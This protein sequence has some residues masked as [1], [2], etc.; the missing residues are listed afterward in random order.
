MVCRFS[1]WCGVLVGRD[2][3]VV[4]NPTAEF[5]FNFIPL[6]LPTKVVEDVKVVLPACEG[7]A[8][9]L[10]MV[11]APHPEVAVNA[12]PPEA[13]ADRVSSKVDESL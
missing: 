8:P 12:P 5:I 10:V 3:T 13:E 2:K 7:D 9:P 11:D 6:N 1:Y 4:R